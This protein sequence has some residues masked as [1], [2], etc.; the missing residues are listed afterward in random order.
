MAEYLIIKNLLKKINPLNVFCCIILLLSIN[1]LNRK[2]N[3]VF[4][5]NQVKKSDINSV[6][7][8]IE[9][10][11][12][13]CSRLYDLYDSLKLCEFLNE[14]YNTIYKNEQN[15]RIGHFI[16]YILYP[17]YLEDR[18]NQLAY[19]FGFVPMFKM[20]DVYYNYHHI[21]IVYYESS[22]PD[23]LTIEFENKARLS[24]TLFLNDDYDKDLT[25]IKSTR[26][27]FVN[28]VF[29]KY[30]CDDFIKCP[31]ILVSEAK[32]KLTYLEAPF[33]TNC[34]NYHSK[35]FPFSKD[36]VNEIKV[37]KIASN[38]DCRNECIKT[39]YRSKYLYY[40]SHINAQLVNFS[41]EESLILDDDKELLNYCHKYCSN[42]NCINFFHIDNLKSNF[43]A[44]HL[45][46]TVFI[47]TEPTYTHRI[48][49]ALQ[50]RY[51]FWLHF[52]S[53]FNC[54][55]GL[56]FLNIFDMFGNFLRNKFEIK[57]E[58]NGNRIIE[59]L[60]WSTVII[61]NIFFT[62]YLVFLLIKNQ[63]KTE[64]YY[65]S[66]NQTTFKLNLCFPLYK[67][68]KDNP[69]FDETR[70]TAAEHVNFD[71]YLNLTLKKLNEMTLGFED[72]FT[73]HDLFKKSKVNYF[74]KNKCFELDIDFGSEDKLNFNTKVYPFTSY[75][76]LSN[77]LFNTMIAKIISQLVPV[78]SIEKRT[79]NCINYRNV[80]YGSSNCFSKKACIDMCYLNEY[81]KNH[82]ALP[83]FLIQE[84]DFNKFEDFRFRNEF[85]KDIKAFCMKQFEAKSCE[86]VHMYRTSYL[87]TLDLSNV[88]LNSLTV[89]KP[90]R[91][92]YLVHEESYYWTDLFIDLFNLYTCL[93]LVNLLILKLK[94]NQTNHIISIMV[95]IACTLFFILHI[96][97][98]LASLD[99]VFKSSYFKNDAR[100]DDFPS[101]NICLNMN[102]KL[103]SD[104]FNLQESSN[105][106]EYGYQFEFRTNQIRL[107]NIVDKIEY[108]NRNYELKIERPSNA[109]TRNSR[110]IPYW[111][112][113]TIEVSY[114]YLMDRK[115][116]SLRYLIDPK[117][118]R[119]HFVDYL[120]SIKFKPE[121]KDLRY[122]MLILHDLSKLD[123]LKS[124]KMLKF[125]R[126]YRLKLIIMRE[127][128][129]DFF[130]MT[131]Y[132][133]IDKMKVEYLKRTNFT[134][135]R[136]PLTEEYFVFKIND[137]LFNKSFVKSFRKRFKE[138][139]FITY[140]ARYTESEKETY[141]F[142]LKKDFLR[143]MI[144][145]EKKKNFTAFFIEILNSTSTW[146][147]LCLFD[148]IFLL[149]NNFK[150]IF[151]LKMKSSQVKPS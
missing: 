148:L 11:K 87:A 139:S 77:E 92:A 12:Y 129:L 131:S 146:Y 4:Y 127:Q 78:V 28:D 94:T 69:Y 21:C 123:D 112:D 96:Y 32:I 100:P 93:G 85:D 42:P 113:K 83:F 97:T 17:P 102:N 26:S 18:Q 132:D 130:D 84:K 142:R 149:I 66:F 62:I 88:S 95:K 79:G 60:K 107:D 116:I 16:N 56:S 141:N 24:V 143:N 86:E 23:S 47:E 150:F 144:R 118:I 31:A 1:S 67:S 41:K 37:E 147:D 57:E 89:F 14:F 135:Q 5:E 138:L 128:V 117:N 71:K 90:T 50:P 103:I 99:D 59:L 53:L 55:F 106:S 7:V 120:L 68:L 124:F 119:L 6:S 110:N 134:T 137:S 70:I 114:F 82:N 61:L 20:Y 108:I 46:N 30:E 44:T 22:E 63:N 19:Y 76:T 121:L 36:N 2:S 27:T 43:L 122:E 13:D 52:L 125:D 15:L 133:T 115:C 33:E 104:H 35:E 3:R 49:R 80:K 73:D 9:I 81:V 48:G 105:L 140:L 72:L 25:G 40:S 74:F 109:S 29:L 65:S 54:V 151:G 45:N 58:S 98:I 8:C 64:L 91:I 145:Y 39:K 111:I 51:T 34:I 38:L 10:K 101:I 75:L 136:L 126:S